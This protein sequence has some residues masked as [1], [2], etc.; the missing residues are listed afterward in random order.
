MVNAQWEM[1]R[2]SLMP[3]IGLL[4]AG[5]MLAPGIGSGNSA[6]SI[7]V[8]GLSASWSIAGLYKR[9]NEKQ[10]TQLSLNKIN[11]QEETFLFNTKLQATQ[12]SANVEKQKA[13]LTGDDEIVSLRKSIRESYQ[14]KYQTGTGSLMDLLNATEKESEARSQKALHEMQLLITI[15]EQKTITGN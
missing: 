3:K 13:I 10:L 11:L 5:V 15:Y 9:G 8:A 1:Q 6:T 14:V 4:G 7:G 12:A 2:V